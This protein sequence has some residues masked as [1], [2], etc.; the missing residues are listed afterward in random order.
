MITGYLYQVS[1]VTENVVSQES[2]TNA[3]DFDDDDGGGLVS[4]YSNV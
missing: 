1:A 3:T 2:G 4:Q